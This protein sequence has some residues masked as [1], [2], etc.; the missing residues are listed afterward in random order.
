MWKG[1]PFCWE[2][3]HTKALDQLIQMVTTALVLGCP[4]PEQQYFLKIDTSSFALE[5]ILF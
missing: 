5:A 4:D 3:Q 2:D 1:V